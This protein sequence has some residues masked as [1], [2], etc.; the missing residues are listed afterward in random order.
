[1]K[2]CIVSVLLGVK[3]KKFAKMFC[4]SYSKRVP[5]ENRPQVIFV[6]DDEKDL[7]LE[8]YKDFVS[9][10]KIPAEAI[11]DIDVNKTRGTGTIR[12]FDYSL[13]RYGYLQALECGYTNICFIDADMEIRHWDMDVISKCDK[14]GIWAGRGYPSSGFGTKPVSKVQDVKF[15]PKLSAL[16]KELKYETDWVKYTLPFEAVML[17]KDIPEDKIREW[18]DNWAKVSYTTKKLNLPKNKVT[19]EIGLAADMAKI[20]VHYNK[21]LLG[22]VF[23]HYIMNHQKL[24]DKHDNK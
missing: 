1:M 11:E 16:K 9:L 15:T 21:E 17:I 12:S 22:V 10:Y 24:L 5:Q 7:Y 6:V 3:Y 8:E 18:L 23:K 2:W 14:P 20:P 19:H 13:K 4:E